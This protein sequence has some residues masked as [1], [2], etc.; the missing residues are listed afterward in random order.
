MTGLLI[1]RLAG[2][3]AYGQYATAFALAGAFAQAFLFGVDSIL[4]REIAKRPEAAAHVFINTLLP[5]VLWSALIAVG[6]VLVGVQLGYT[7]NVLAILMMAAPIFALRGLINLGRAALRGLE[8]MD[9]DALIQVIETLLVL[10][11]VA[12]TF[13]VSPSIRHV[14][15][16]M[17]VAEL[18][19]LGYTARLIR[20]Y[21]T[22]SFR[23]ARRTSLQLMRAAAPLGAT[24]MLIGFNFR[25]D[26][27]ILSTHHSETEVGLYAA[28]FGIIVLSSALSLVAAALLPRL[29]ALADSNRA[30]FGALWSTG[31]R[32]TLIIGLGVGMSISWLAP[33][34]IQLLYGA[35]FAAAIPVLRVLG[36]VATLLFI[37]RY[38]WHVLIALGQQK[39]ILLSAIVSALATLACGLTLI[40]AW[41]VYGAAVTAIVREICQLAVLGYFA[42]RCAPAIRWREA[43]LAPIGAALTMLFI[44]IFVQVQ[45]L[46][47]M[48][49]LF[50]L[51][52]GILL[53]L[54]GLLITN[55]IQR[56]ELAGWSKR[57]AVLAVI[58]GG[59]GL[60][61]HPQAALAAQSCPSAY[62]ALDANGDGRAEALQIAAHF[63]PAVQ[64]QITVYFSADQTDERPADRS[65]WTDYVDFI[66]ETWVF[67]AGANGDA[68]L[69]IFFARAGNAVTA[70]LYDDQDGD[71]AVTYAVQDNRVVIGET[72][73]K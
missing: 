28:A 40:P 64:D 69:I 32:Y 23:F 60:L 68:N 50:M 44:L 71:N 63:S 56:R 7:G 27:I 26:T 2:L 14:I 22:D 45:H 72:L 8:R 42:F 61:A 4:P 11:A 29:S 41:G 59:A 43:V 52:L 16:A 19:A 31:L 1:A 49:A 66:D 18:L 36:I 57:L 39:S 73:P 35:E 58:A 47:D 70:E 54:A 67:D 13:A 34:L 24:F 15:L 20:R 12:V 3:D 9:M 48:Y 37:N 5:V 10:V 21:C 65:C 46:S 17:L 51:P 30:E 33:W 25:L 6:I 62:Q 38:V 53:Y 55:G